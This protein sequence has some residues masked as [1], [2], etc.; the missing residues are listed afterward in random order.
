MDIDPPP[1]Y[2]D[3][4]GLAHPFTA[5]AAAAPLWVEAHAQQTVT[6]QQP[7]DRSHGAKEIAPG[8]AA[9]E[10]HGR[11]Q[12]SEKEG[13]RQHRRWRDGQFSEGQRVDVEPFQHG[14]RQI[15]CAQH[16]RLEQL[17][18]QSAEQAPG[19]EQVQQGK[20]AAECGKDGKD[21]EGVPDNL[22]RRQRRPRQRP[23]EADTCIL[24]HPQRT[25]ER[26]VDPAQQERP[27]KQQQQGSRREQGGI[28]D[29]AQ[30]GRH[31]L[32]REKKRRKKHGDLRTPEKHQ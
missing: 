29:A 1:T 18:C 5:T 24:H 19:I 31:R 16:Q 28:P 10:G 14:G 25:E 12:Q 6:G 30:R 13:D 23:A 17:A 9:T 22:K 21:G 3:A 11:D 20:G 26:A 4:T 2:I 27:R 32:E 7:Q 8:T 15:A